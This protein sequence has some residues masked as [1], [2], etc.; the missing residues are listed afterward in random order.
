SWRPASGARACGIERM[1]EFS[2]E[3][4]LMIEAAQAAGEGLQRRYADLAA[5]QARTKSGPADLVSIAD[6]EAEREVRRVL[7]QGGHGYA[8]LGEEGGASGSGQTQWIVDP[9]DGTTNFLF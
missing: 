3:M 6:E 7:E 8:F 1:H 4:R 2:R 5:L 9:L